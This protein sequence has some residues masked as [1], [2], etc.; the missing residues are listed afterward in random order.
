MPSDKKKTFDEI[1]A[2][3]EEL[4]SAYGALFDVGIGAPPPL[5][6]STDSLRQIAGQEAEIS[7]LRGD[8]QG[9]TPGMKRV[10][11]EATLPLLS[12]WV[13]RRGRFDSAI[14]PFIDKINAV[15]DFD[16]KKAD[17]ERKVAQKEAAIFAEA[18]AHRPYCDRKVAKEGADRHYSL[19]IQRVG[20]RPVN[21]FGRT[22]PYL[23]ILLAITSVEW[24]INY[25]AFLAW[26]RSPMIASGFTIGAALAVALAAHV[27]GEYLKQRN[28][29]FGAASLTKGRDITYIVLATA[30]LLAAVV[31]AGWARYSLAMKDLITDGPTIQVEGMLQKASPLTDVY[32]SLGINLIVW[33]VALVIAF[34][35]H[36]E[37]HELLSAWFDQ[38]RRTNQF[39]RAHKRWARQIR[40]VKAGGALELNELYAATDLA[41]SAVKK[42]SDM[43]DQVI[44]R[45]EAF[46]RQLAN[47]LQGVVDTYRIALGTA[48]RENGHQV[49]VG[50]RVC[51]GLQYQNLEIRLDAKS[52][53]SIIN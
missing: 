25:E 15:R 45:E 7:S 5:S 23:L 27:H 35:A 20:G 17:I 26:T 46:Y 49:I 10:L 14:L 48:L 41:K 12:P 2:P 30:A 3:S 50:E 16:A 53:R 9:F 11:R 37:N 28:S 22:W 19:C 40:T 42:Q 8:A 18:E 1:A 6:V 13:E 43:L 29:R 44:Q 39:N 47:H 51:S 52:L 24:L 36:D 33:L 4:T 34:M 31:V 38:R 32:F 21:F